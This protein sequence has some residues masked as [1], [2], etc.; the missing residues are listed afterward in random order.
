MLSD[1]DK[2]LLIKLGG[3][4]TSVLNGV[5][6][7]LAVCCKAAMLAAF[8]DIRFRPNSMTALTSQIMH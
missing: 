7:N 2:H 3:L 5:T 6:I 1:L 4:D 8:G